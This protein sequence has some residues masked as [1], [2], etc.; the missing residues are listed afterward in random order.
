MDNT[1]SLD[2]IANSGAIEDIM[3]LLDRKFSELES[4]RRTENLWV[5][6]LKLVDIVKLFIYAERCGD[7]DLHPYSVMLMLPYFHAAGHLNY[8]KDCSYLFTANA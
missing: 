8:A 6:Y 2:D 3:N 4:S 1:K 7:W 5:Q